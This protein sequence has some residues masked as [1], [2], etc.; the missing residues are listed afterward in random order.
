MYN[1]DKCYL[2]EV[3]PTTNEGSRK[4]SSNNGCLI[5]FG[6]ILFAFLSIFVKPLFKSY[7]HY[8]AQERADETEEEA[9][10]PVRGFH[11]EETHEGQR[12]DIQVEIGGH[13]GEQQEH[14]VLVHERLGQVSPSGHK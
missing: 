14:G 8:K 11:P 1:S 12:E 10:D 2:E 7:M 5:V 13:S 4:K 9:L 6:I 3:K